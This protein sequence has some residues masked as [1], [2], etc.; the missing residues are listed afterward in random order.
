M[1]EKFELHCKTVGLVL[2]CIGIY[3]SLTSLSLLAQKG[4]DITKLLPQSELKMFAPSYLAEMQATA[5]YAR[6]HAL[7]SLLLS[8]IAPI[9]LGIYLMRSRNLFVRLCYPDAGGPPSASGAIGA[10]ARLDVPP[11]APGNANDKDL[12]SRY[13]PPGYFD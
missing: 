1:R 2:F 11:K 12:G 13:A 9:L 10:P 3:S 5:S 7:T 8:G 6:K 4:P